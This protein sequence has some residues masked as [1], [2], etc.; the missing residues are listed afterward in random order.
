MAVN[1]R[2]NNRLAPIEPMMTRSGLP[3]SERILKREIN[4]RFAGENAAILR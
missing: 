2:S 3:I 4:V 1:E